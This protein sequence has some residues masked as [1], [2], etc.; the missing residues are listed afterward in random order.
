MESEIQFLLKL[1]L[2]HKLSPEVKKLCLARIGEVEQLLRTHAPQMARPV[3][4]QP[5]AGLAALAPGQ[6]CAS[7]QALLEKHGML[8]NA[9][10][11]IP[12]VAPIQ[13]VPVSTPVPIVAQTQATAQALASRNAALAQAISGKPEPGRTSPRKF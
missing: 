4:P 6:Q 3:A 7:T 8:D 2:E 1:L 9:S 11:P 10:P 5:S 13:P 12:A